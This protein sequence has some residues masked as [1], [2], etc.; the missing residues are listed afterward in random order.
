MSEDSHD[1]DG[2]YDALLIDRQSDAWEEFLMSGR[3]TALANFLQHGGEVDQEVRDIL[4][5]IL[6]NDPKL[7]NKGGRDRWRDYTTFVAIKLIFLG[8]VNKTEACR[9]YA[10]ETNQEQRTVEMRYDRGEKIYSSESDLFVK[11]PPNL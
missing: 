10:E 6:R 11:V 5:D 8:G 2:R 3:P 1:D 9:R 7:L 4:I